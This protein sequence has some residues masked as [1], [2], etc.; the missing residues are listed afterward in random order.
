MA[1]V[2]GRAVVLAP[3]R[4]SEISPQGRVGKNRADFGGIP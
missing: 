2:A 3:L 4:D 1:Q